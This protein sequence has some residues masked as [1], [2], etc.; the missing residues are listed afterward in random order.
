MRIAKHVLDVIDQTM[1][2]LFCATAILAAA[3]VVSSGV[4][5]NT[6]QAANFTEILDVT[7]SEGVVTATYGN[8]T[9]FQQLGCHRSQWSDSSPFW[10]Q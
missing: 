1:H 2:S 8:G 3:S 9:V 7:Y 10:M 5:T 6:S 4:A